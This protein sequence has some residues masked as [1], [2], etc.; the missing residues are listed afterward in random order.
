[1]RA[2]QYTPVILLLLLIFITGCLLTKPELKAP[3][4]NETEKAMGIN[5]TKEGIKYLVD[6]AKVLPGG[7]QK[8]GIGVDRGIPAIN[9]PKFISVQEADTWID[10]NEL[11]MF[12]D[13]KGVKRIY[14]L[15]IMVWHEIVDDVVAGD[16]LLISYCP[17][18]G[19]AIAYERNINGKVVEFGTTGKL[20]NSD[21]VMYDDKTDTFWTQIGGLGIIG[22]LTGTKLNPVS[23]DTLV[24]EDIK[25]THPDAQVLSKETGFSRDYG[26]DPYGN[27]YFEDYLLFPVE[28]ESKKVSPKTVVFGIE[29]NDV[30]KAYKEE[31][32][33]ELKEIDDVIDSVKVK[34]TRDRAGIVKIINIDTGKEIIK[35][36][37]FW[38]A[39]YA[40]HPDT[41]LY[42][43]TT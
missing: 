29:V 26:R 41:Q 27:Y 25:T 43:R 40:F 39:W 38:F 7:P 31:D 32:I 22:P 8:G 3:E 13:Y 42:Q 15:Q 11:V 9:K 35:E 28:H 5:V 12:L 14:P 21:L 19:S 17:L 18:C 30:F 34:I 24:W 10:D 23:I 2:T 33:K 20:Y 37:D 4:L 16:P 6:P 36:R 1:M